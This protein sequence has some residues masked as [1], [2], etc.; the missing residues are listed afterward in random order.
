MSLYPGFGAKRG[1]HVID[2]TGSI[3]HDG[4]MVQRISQPHR[5]PQPRR[6]IIVAYDGLQPLDLVGPHEVFDGANRLLA[7]RPTDHPGYELKVVSEFGGTIT[8]TSGLGLATHPWSDLDNHQPVDTLII[9][10]GFAATDPPTTPS[11]VKWL[12]AI[13]ST[14]RRVCCVCTGAFLAAEAGLL[15]GRTVS[16]HWAM[17][18]QLAKRFPDITVNADAIYVNDGPIWTSAG[19][20]A[21]LDVSLALVEADHGPELAQEVARWLV[22]FLRRPGGQSQFATPA[23]T[24]PAQSASLRDVQHSIVAAPHDDHSIAAMATRA[25]MSIRTFQRTFRGQVGEPPARYVERIRV[26]V[27]RHL[28][29][30]TPHGL[31]FVA[32]S[33]GFSTTETLRRAF[34]RHVGVSPDQYRQRFALQPRP[35][36]TP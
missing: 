13:G 1:I 34:S 26:D 31:T 27:A 2:A 16:T 10:G 5:A 35:D 12:R 30:T 36:P 6:V 28:L 33:S 20:T 25:S 11:L 4:P 22:M 15:N 23:W 29:E 17:T 19:V 8:S 9:P 14:S 18:S 7:A 32:Q 21:G 24:K 3:R